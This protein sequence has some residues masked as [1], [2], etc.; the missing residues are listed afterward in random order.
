MK[1][2]NQIGRVSQETISNSVLDITALCLQKM[3]AEALNYLNTFC[4][5]NIDLVNDPKGLYNI[6]SR[7]FYMGT[8]DDLKNFTNQYLESNIKAI[9]KEMETI[10]CQISEALKDGDTYLSGKLKMKKSGLEIA[11]KIIKT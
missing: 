2:I 11:L 7:R 8:Q 4:P 1:L 9:E 6:F 10:D 3:N 5:I